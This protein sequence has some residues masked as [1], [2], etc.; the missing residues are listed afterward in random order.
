[1]VGTDGRGEG[2]LRR[3]VSGPHRSTLDLTRYAAV[4]GS[5]S[6]L[7]APSTSR[8]RGVRLVVRERTGKLHKPAV[9]RSVD[10]PSRWIHSTRPSPLG[11]ASWPRI[12]ERRRPPRP[13]RSCASRRRGAARQQRSW[14]GSRGCSTAGRL[15]PARSPRSPSIA[16]PL[17]NW[18][19]GWP[20]C[21]PRWAWR[22]VRSGSGHSMP[23]GWR[24]SAR[25]DNPWTSWTGSPSSAGSCPRL[26]RRAGGDSTRPSPGSSWTS[27][28]PPTR[29][30]ATRIRGP[31]R[32]PS[33]HTSGSWSPR[34][35]STSTT[36][37]RARFGSSRRT[38]PCA[39]AGGRAARTCSW[40]RP[41]TST[42]PSSGWRSSSPRPPTGSSSSATTISRST[43]GAW[44]TSAAS[45][46]WRTTCRACAG[47]ISS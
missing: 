44:P 4:N 42:A 13:G 18:T 32:G 23:S 19:S 33:S 47:S 28:S 8:E 35:G 43:A 46:P 39:S 2:D 21:S 27:G 31:W 29:S 6:P 37:W 22:R 16:R 45:S 20:R 12:S 5:A 9:S 34:A 36:S 10:P 30:P 1:M 15:A 11:W 38:R 26:V 7:N 17:S 24:S 41:R 40:T 14:P 3:G 25:P